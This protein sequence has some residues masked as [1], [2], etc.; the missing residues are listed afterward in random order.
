MIPAQGFNVT[1]RARLAAMAFIA[2]GAAC[3]RS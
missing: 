1:Y 3:A 2:M